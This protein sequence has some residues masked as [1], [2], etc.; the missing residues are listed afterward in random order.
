[1]Y[2]ACRHAL[3]SLPRVAG[4]VADDL[5]RAHRASATWTAENLARTLPRYARTHLLR[6]RGLLEDATSERDLLAELLLP[7]LDAA[8]VNRVVYAS[9]WMQTIQ[10]LTKLAAPDMLAWKIASLVQQ[11]KSVQAIAREIRPAVQEVQ[12]S[13][14]RVARTAGLWVAHEAERDVYRG[15]E[16]D[17]IIGYTIRAVRD[18]VTRPKHLARDGQRF[19]IRPVA[20]QR[21]MSECPRPPREAD[22]SWAFNCRCW[23]EP[24]L[25]VE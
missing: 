25:S 22:G 12:T 21:P 16:G 10:R 15:L 6:R 17:L 9:G 5:A 24:I 1:V 18:R 2:A 4:A 23:R 3:H 11:G 19:Y 7:P 14:R 8:A 13:A 20:G